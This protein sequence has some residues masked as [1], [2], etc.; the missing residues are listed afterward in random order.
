MGAKIHAPDYNRGS[1]SRGEVETAC[2][3]N[4]EID[5]AGDRYRQASVP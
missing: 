5:T 2:N 1:P 4:L 3:L